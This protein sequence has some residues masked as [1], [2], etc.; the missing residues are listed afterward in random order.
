MATIKRVH[1]GVQG[2]SASTIKT[3]FDNLN[4][5]LIEVSL[6]S[7][8]VVLNVDNVVEVLFNFDA[9]RTQVRYNGA[10]SSYSII[11]AYN[12]LG[13][14]VLF[15]ENVFYVQWNCEYGAGRRFCFLYEK[16]KGI[17]YFGA[18]GAGME[19]GS[20]HA[21]YSITDLTLLNISTGVTFSHGIILNYSV[22]QG[23]IHYTSDYLFG[24]GYKTSDVDAN[25]IT[26]SSVPTDRII[27]F[28]SHNYYSVGA[29]TLI[30]ID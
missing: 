1:Y 13:L 25:F 7:Y 19:T 22:E 21:W 16:I 18:I 3:F 2:Y 14:T 11:N 5:P 6:T 12:P 30:G 15:D 27:T 28:K 4:C 17:S 29:N 23:Y 20:G 10:T 26:C 8:T 24:E 9:G